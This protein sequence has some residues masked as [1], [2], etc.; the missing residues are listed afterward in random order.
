M[1]QN[2]AVG[3][4][5]RHN[6]RQPSGTGPCIAWCKRR[7]GIGDTSEVITRNRVKPGAAGNGLERGLVECLGERGDVAE[8]H[9]N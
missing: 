3:K 8:R 6:F 1:L 5:Y 9:T 7:A 4:G 2:G